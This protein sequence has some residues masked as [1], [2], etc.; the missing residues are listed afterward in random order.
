MLPL[1]HIKRKDGVFANYGHAQAVNALMRIEKDCG[2]TSIDAQ[3]A[4]FAMSIYSNYTKNG[5]RYFLDKTPRYYHILHDLIRIFPHAKFIV[6]TRNPISVFASS[7]LG[8]RQNSTRRLDHLDEDFYQ[9]PVKIS[10]FVNA[11][12]EQVC[13]IRY[14]DLINNAENTVKV[15][16]EYLE[17]DYCKTMIDRSFSTK[18][19]GHGDHLGLENINK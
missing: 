15:I 16:C 5:E 14:E 17:V 1:C 9:G 12:R 3:I 13:L 11:H 4:D 2:E 8:L 6:L 10:Q 7:I 19:L 18:L